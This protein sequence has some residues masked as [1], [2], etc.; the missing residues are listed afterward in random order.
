[1]VS[2]R[3]SS[4]RLL[5]RVL[6]KVE[7]EHL[8]AEFA[9][10]HVLMYVIFNDLSSPDAQ[11]YL[12]NAALFNE[13]CSSRKLYSPGA[14]FYAFLQKLCGLTEISRMKKGRASRPYFLRH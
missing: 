5:E 3:H 2:I 9:C 13:K 8:L 1:M 11:W 6:C 4:Y 7:V 12:R 10:A 14:K